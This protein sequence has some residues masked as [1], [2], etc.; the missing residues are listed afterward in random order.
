M[1]KRGKEALAIVWGN[2]FILTTDHKALEIMFIRYN[3]Q[4][5][6]IRSYFVNRDKLTIAPTEYGSILLFGN[7]LVIEEHLQKTAV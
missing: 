1:W 5:P 3:I 4:Q 6:C 7:R 2:G